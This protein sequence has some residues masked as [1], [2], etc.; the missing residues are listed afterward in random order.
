MEYGLLGRSLL[1]LTGIV[2]FA[3]HARRATARADR[4]QEPDRTTTP[5]GKLVFGIFGSMA[6]FERDMLRQQNDAGLAAARKR[7]PGG[8]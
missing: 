8:P 3:E 7:G 1:H 2:D 5:S 4:E 6:E